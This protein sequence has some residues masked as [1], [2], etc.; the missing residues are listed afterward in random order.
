MKVGQQILQQLKAA[1][2]ILICFKNIKHGSGYP[3]G[4]D[5]VASAL[6]LGAFL[7]KN[8]KAADIVSPNFFLPAHFSFLPGSGAI[9]KE[10]NSSGPSDG[11]K[12]FLYVYSGGGAYDLI[13]IIGTPELDLL[14]GIYEENRT[15]FSTAPIINIDNSPENKSCGAINLIDTESSSV[16]EIV[17][18]IIRDSDPDENAANCILSGIIAKTKKFRTTGINP[19][20]L[21]T[22]GDLVK[23]GAKRQKII[24]KFYRTKSI[25]AL[26]LWGRALTRL[27]H[28][29]GIV[30]SAL[31]RADFV[32]SGA[33]EADLPDVIFELISHSPDAKIITL[34][35]ESL[36][37]TIKSVAYSNNK[38]THAVSP[39]PNLITAEK[40]LLA[41]LKNKL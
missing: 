35:F 38:L 16:A 23:L 8:G 12:N 26:R 39:H 18:Q 32:H 20:T 40:E 17:W 24:E 1:Q 11:D 37:G 2:N 36:D 3:A 21:E 4:G 41:E 34:I 14:G 33:T 9:K 28:D 22:V 19:K 5:A 6:A 29:G 10:I 7:R 30:W 15:Q 25:E 13:I 31:Q 27:K